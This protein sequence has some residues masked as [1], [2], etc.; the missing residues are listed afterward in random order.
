MFK[1]NQL[2][3]LTLWTKIVVGHDDRAFE[4]LV[5]KYQ[6]DVRRFFLHQTLGGRDAE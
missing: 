3:D 5:Q 2:D 6:G 1:L 4:K